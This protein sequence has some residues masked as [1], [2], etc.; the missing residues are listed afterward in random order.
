[1]YA[2]VCSYVTMTVGIWMMVSTI[3]YAGIH[4]AF[5]AVSFGLCILWVIFAILEM[6]AIASA[7][8][9]FNSTHRYPYFFF[10]GCCGYA[11]SV[12]ILIYFHNFDG[13]RD[14]GL[15]AFM[16]PFVVSFSIIVGGV[17]SAAI[18]G[19]I[20]GMIADSTR[21]SE[22]YDDMDLQDPPPEWI[23]VSA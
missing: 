3:I 21:S 7:M 2:R 22:E 4:P 18:A 5:P 23:P 12:P 20:C 16:D 19:I 15:T 13:A 11:V 9:L 8:W 1:M 6:S 14:V 17:L 10:F